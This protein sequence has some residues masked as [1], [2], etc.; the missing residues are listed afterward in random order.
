MRTDKRRV[1]VVEDELLVAMGIEMVLED[2]G[3]LVIGPIAR[4]QEAIEAARDAEMDVAL[5]DVNLRG[6]EVYPV[7][8]IL[9]ERHIPF[10]FLTGYGPEI[11]PT[12]YAGRR[13]LHK[14]FVSDMVT[15][16]VDSLAGSA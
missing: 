7:A 11:L 13:V 9:A 6:D 5:L 2:A 16:M 12:R 8:D 14:P 10:A 4:L 1:L 3:C 15:K